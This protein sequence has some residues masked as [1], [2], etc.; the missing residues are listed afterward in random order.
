LPTLEAF[1][2]SQSFPP[3]T[4][5][6]PASQTVGL[7]ATSNGEVQ[8]PGPPCSSASPTG[9]GAPT[10][11]DG[12][13]QRVD[14]RPADTSQ[15]TTTGLPANVSADTRTPGVPVTVFVR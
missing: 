12:E 9:R 7:P 8:L 6:T 5:P 2:A 11:S 15:P 13:S 14:L 10:S 1:P 4:P 3:P